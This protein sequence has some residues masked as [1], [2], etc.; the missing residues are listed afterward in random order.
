MNTLFAREVYVRLTDN[1]QG[2][3]CTVKQG[4]FFTKTTRFAFDDSFPPEAVG[5]EAVVTLKQRSC[6][7]ASRGIT[8]E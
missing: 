5:E 6:R 3:V 8:E 1:K 7:Q 4:R 2:F